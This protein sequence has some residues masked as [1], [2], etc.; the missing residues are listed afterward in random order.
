MKKLCR[1]SNFFGDI[2]Q[3]LKHEYFYSLHQPVTGN[4]RHVFGIRVDFSNDANRQ[5]EFHRRVSLR[6]GQL[7][8]LLRVQVQ[9]LWR[10]MRHLRDIV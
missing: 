4:A 3:E 7:W 2:L 1:R 5:S 9:L 6:V 8:K 10:Q